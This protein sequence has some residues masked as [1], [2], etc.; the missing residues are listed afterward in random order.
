MSFLK[1]KKINNFFLKL[2]EKINQLF[3]FL[4]LKKKFKNHDE[5]LMAQ[6]RS[7][8]IPSLK[9]FKYLSKSLSKKEWLFFRIAFFVFILSILFIVANVFLGKTKI[10]PRVG[11][12]Y[13]EALVGSPKFINP[14]YASINDVD[15]DIASLVFSGLV[16]VDNHQQIVPDLAERWEVSEDQKEYTFYLHDDLKWHD[17]ENL[18]TEDVLFTYQM[19][20]DEEFKSPLYSIFL[21]VE[22]QAIDDKTIKFVLPGSYSLFLEN[23][24]VGIMPAHLWREVLPAN[25]LLADYNM[26]P[27]GSGPYKFKNLIKDKL[28]NIKSYTIERNKKYHNG[29]VFIKEINFKF[30]PDFISATE[31]FKGHNVDG[32][33]YL[34]NNL[35]EN[36]SLRK[37]VVKNNFSLPQYT[38]LFF[39]QQKNESLKE[40]AVRQALAYAIDKDFLTNEVLGSEAQKIEAPILAGFIGYNPNIAKYET[41]IEKAKTLLDEAGWK[42]EKVEIK[43]DEEV[44]STRVVRVNK[45]DE[46]LKLVITT[47][48]RVDNQLV[49][50]AIQKMWQELDIQVEVRLVD[51]S[52]IQ[53]KVIRNRDFEILLFGENFGTDPDPYPFWHS[54]QVGENGLNLANFVNKE[55]DQVLE[56]ARQISDPQKRHDK[57]VHFQNIL[58]KYLP[59]IFLYTPKYTYPVTGDIKGMDTYVIAN[60][61]DR[62][63]NIVNWY[64]ETRR[65]F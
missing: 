3:Y 27:V 56:E 11:G 41:D 2:G 17:R 44:V 26:R 25:I 8:K 34:P 52:E 14:L 10:V 16:R 45:D 53:A 63:S 46:E 31:A 60:P 12:T 6:L 57:Y 50:E 39:N 55:S 54:S 40:L 42:V 64:I 5:K 18:T 9:Q 51:V 19:I 37:D 62:F 33:S 29:D 61:S 24:T 35:E 48:D 15:Q 21:D 30:Y 58:N 49:A 47:V 59:A 23:L 32:I 43:K 13:T 7:K 28:G 22:M 4:R 65:K 38:A 1:S 36:I 20:Q